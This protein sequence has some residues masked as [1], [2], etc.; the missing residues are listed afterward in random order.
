[1]QK[2][3]KNIEWEFTDK[4]VTSW[5]GLRMFKEFLDKTEIRSELKRLAMPYPGSNRGYDPIKLIE[6]FWVSVWVGAANF[7]HTAVIR[8]D[9]GIKGIFGWKNLP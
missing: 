5:G 7:S 8:F 4:K 2:E 1:M 3:I 6:S 9:E